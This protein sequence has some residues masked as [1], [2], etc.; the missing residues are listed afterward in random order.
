MSQFD[1]YRNNGRQREA[2]PFVVSLVRHD[3][4]GM[5]AGD[6]II[7]SLDRLLSRACR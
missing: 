3:F 1:V 5:I 7:H 2:I 6:R 4:L